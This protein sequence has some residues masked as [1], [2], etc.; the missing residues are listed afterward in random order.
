MSLHDEETYKVRDCEYILGIL[1]FKVCIML[2]CLCS[3]HVVFV[4][5]G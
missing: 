2:N 1:G 5:N 3:I 4:W